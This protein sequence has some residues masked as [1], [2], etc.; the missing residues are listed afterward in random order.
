MSCRDPD[1]LISPSDD[2]NFDYLFKIVLIGDCG[3]GKTCVLQRFKS[4]TFVE[5]HGNTIGVD[6]CIKTVLIDGKRIKLQIWDTAG[7]ERFRTITQSYYRSANGIIIGNKC[8]LE[9]QREV[10]KAEA[11]ALCQYLPEVLHV[12]ET[13]AKDNTNVD[14]IFFYLA[15][16]LKRRHDNRQIS[17]NEN[18][19]VKLSV[20]RDLSSCSGCSYKI[21]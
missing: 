8:D 1:N 19:V 18:D 21:F 3:T 6:F 13:S 9:H 10:K 4:G 16:E 12:V 7:Q 15:S 14:S 5:R 17:T 2:E 20:G 11:E